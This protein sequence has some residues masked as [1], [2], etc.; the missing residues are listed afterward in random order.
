MVSAA[1]T[2]ED[3]PAIRMSHRFGDVRA[4][5]WRILFLPARSSRFSASSGVPEN[6]NQF[7]RDA[8]EIYR[9]LRIQANMNVS[10]AETHFRSVIV[11][12]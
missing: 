10:A 6:P 11:V 7:I 3:R 12:S 9:N 5:P 4:C 2:S 8:V 1:A